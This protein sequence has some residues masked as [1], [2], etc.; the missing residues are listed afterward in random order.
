MGQ[1]ISKSVEKCFSFSKRFLKY[2]NKALK[3]SYF[4]ANFPA[5]AICFFY[6]KS[7]SYKTCV[8]I[9]MSCFGL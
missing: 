3:V 4:W 6:D 8:H 1:I 2:L 7:S 9:F 5:R